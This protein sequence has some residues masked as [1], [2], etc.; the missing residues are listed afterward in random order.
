MQKH[1]STRRVLI[2]ALMVVASGSAMAQPKKDI[3][4]GLASASFATATL[5]IANELQLVEKHGLNMRSVVTDNSGMALAGV[6]TKSFDLGIVGLPE[7]IIA[8][9]RGQNIVSAAVTYSGFATSMV[10]SKPAADKIGVAP[11]AP[12]KQR[13]KALDGLVIATPSATAGGTVAFKAAIAAEGANVRMPYITQPAMQAALETGAIDGYL[14]S[15]PFWAFPVVKGGGHI[16][17]SGPKGEFPE[18]STPTVT[19]LLLTTRE[20]ADA[21]PML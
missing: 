14:S 13:L 2:T 17:I 8:R 3:T 9:A 7:F 6:L 16:W 15:A 20:Y 11:A 10:L 5:R 1:S 19:G 18:A 4:V 21:N 12:L